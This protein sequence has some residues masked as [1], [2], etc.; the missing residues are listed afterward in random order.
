MAASVTSNVTSGFFDSTESSRRI[1]TADEFSSIFDGLISDGVYENYPGGTRT[2]N[3]NTVKIPPFEVTKVTSGNDLV[4]SI[5]PGRAWFHHVWA[6]NTTST[7]TLSAAHGTLPRID[8]IYLRVNK[9]ARSCDLACREGTPSS[10]PTGDF[11]SDDNNNE[12]YYYPIAFIKVPKAASSSSS[13]VVTSA[14]GNPNPPANGKTPIVK[15][16]VDPSMTLDEYI[17]SYTE[18]VSARLAAKFAE[19]D[20]WRQTISALLKD[21]VA[22]NLSDA[23]TEVRGDL[24]DL[25]TKHDSDI[26]DL[27]TQITNVSNDNVTLHQADAAI[28]TSLNTLSSYFNNGLY[29]YNST[30]ASSSINKPGHVFARYRM[31]ICPGTMPKSLK[32]NQCTVYT[33]MV[34]PSGTATK[35]NVQVA[36]G[37]GADVIALRR[38]NGSTSWLPWKYVT[39]K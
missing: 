31:D 2:V 23:I 14:I 26:S 21:N 33:Q 8:C 38:K 18:Q 9:G 10:D 19:I 25:E 6:L 16:I 27:N 22:A 4:I 15:A 30:Q 3:G 7:V 13:L 32:G 12:V 35:Y 20:Q 24:D 11:P 34:D 28:N 5:G 17:A 29:L 37:F 36:V 1:Y 39:L